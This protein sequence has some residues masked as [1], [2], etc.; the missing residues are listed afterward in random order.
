MGERAGST[1]RSTA[2]FPCGHFTCSHIPLFRS[3]C[4]TERS[5]HTAGVAGTPHLLGRSPSARLLRDSKSRDANNASKGGRFRATGEKVENLHLCS[6]RAISLTSNC[7][8]TPVG[9]TFTSA[10]TEAFIAGAG[11]AVGNMLHVK[12]ETNGRLSRQSRPE[13]WQM[14]QGAPWTE[15]PPPLM[16]PRASK[17]EAAELPLVIHVSF[18]HPPISDFGPGLRR[19][20][21]LQVSYPLR[22]RQYHQGAEPSGTGPSIPPV[23]HSSEREYRDAISPTQELE[24]A[25]LQQQHID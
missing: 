19:P 1:S 13:W 21:A 6:S 4:G 2:V 12:R 10:F 25:L 23:L 3:T 22:R 7:L 15:R 16:K 20:R 14:V 17:A 24:P 9:S 5:R 8:T 18:S 11:C